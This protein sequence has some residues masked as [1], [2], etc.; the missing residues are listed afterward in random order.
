MRDRACR[1]EPEA[2]RE[3]VTVRLK[4][5]RRLSAPER[6][7]LVAD[8]WDS[9]A[10]APDALPIADAQRQEL[11]RRLAAHNPS[12]TRPWSEVGAR[13]EQRE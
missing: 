5:I 9:I 6:V 7:Q 11:N 13:P 2:E 10:A 12:E 1:I 3:L 4:E 8:I